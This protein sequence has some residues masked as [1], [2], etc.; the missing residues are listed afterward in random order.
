MAHWHHR[1]IHS[2]MQFTFTS[3]SHIHREFVMPTLQSTTAELNQTRMIREDL[4]VLLLKH[5]NREGSPSNGTSESEL[6]AM[7]DA[8]IR[9]AYRERATDIH[10]DPQTGGYRIRFRIDGLMHDAALLTVAQGHRLVNQL[11]TMADIDPV[12]I[13]FPEEARRTYEMDDVTIDLRV[14]IAPCISGVKL[15]I[16]M[17]DPKTVEHRVSDL[18]LSTE[19]LDHLNGWLANLHG[20]FLVA[21]PTGSGKTTTLYALLHELKQQARNILT[22]EDP[23][24][25]Q[26][27]GINQMQV[28]ERHELTF[29]EGLK[30]MLRLDPDYM[31]VGEI[32]DASSSR[33]AVDASN[34]GRVLMSTIHAPDA[35]GAVTSL[36]NWGIRDHEIATALTVVVTQ[37]LVR[38]LCTHCRVMGEPNEAD[39]KWLEAARLPVPEKVWHPRG[40]NKCS[41]IGYRGRT[42]IFEVW[43]LHEDDY[44][45][46]LAHADDHT[47]RQHLALKGHQSMVMHAMEKVAEGITSVEELKMFSG[48]VGALVRR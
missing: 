8:I 38:T 20:L 48:F 21:G 12:T 33:I 24:E 41:D 6:A 39:R 40:C 42:G 17:L 36:R 45:L 14:T 46:I 10:L 11:K 16:R 34:K 30:V 47:M 28:N 35:V 44:A 29:A 43:H 5:L 3:S 13:F 1:A 32:R 9:D 26:I 15:A 23:V 22:I 4:T 19:N 27:D 7:A 25:Y 37:R 31:M 2:I 18:G